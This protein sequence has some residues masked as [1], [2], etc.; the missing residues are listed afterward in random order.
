MA[1]HP[2]ISGDELRARIK[3]LGLAYGRAAERLGLTL[4]GLNKQ[5]RGVNAVSRQTAL[6]LGYVEREQ[7]SER[8]PRRPRRDHQLAQYLYPTASRRK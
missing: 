6:L 8:A 1:L 4:D 5:M 3:H 2:R 7:A